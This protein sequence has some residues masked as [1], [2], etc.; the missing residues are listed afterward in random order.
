MGGIL[1]PHLKSMIDYVFNYVGNS[2]TNVFVFK[3][4]TTRQRQYSATSRFPTKR[5]LT[6]SW[7]IL[8]TETLSAIIQTRWRS[9]ISGVRDSGGFSLCKQPKVMVSAGS[10]VLDGRSIDGGHRAPLSGC[11]CPNWRKSAAPLADAQ[12]PGHHSLVRLHR[13]AERSARARRPCGFCQIG[14]KAGGHPTG[15]RHIGGP[16]AGCG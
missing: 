12:G 11:F 14:P 1:S 5:T 16:R 10:T 2:Q 8:Q 4:E 15:L 3:P 7:T 9:G 13:P 6:T